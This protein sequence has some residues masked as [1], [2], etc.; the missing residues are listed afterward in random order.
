MRKIEFTFN[1]LGAI[2]IAYVKGSKL[3]KITFPVRVPSRFYHSFMNDALLS[4][5]ERYPAI[6]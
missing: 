4:F 5:Y 6:K 1:E 3:E 2:A